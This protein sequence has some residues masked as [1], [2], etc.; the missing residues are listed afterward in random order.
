MKVKK[1]NF[2]VQSQM[3]KLLPF[4]VPDI[5]SNNEAISKN[6]NQSDGSSFAVKTTKTSEDTW[7]SLG[8]NNFKS[9]VPKKMGNAQFFQ[10]C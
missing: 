7:S 10:N 1:K 5:L 4:V 9:P 6:I 3:R 8:A 2:V